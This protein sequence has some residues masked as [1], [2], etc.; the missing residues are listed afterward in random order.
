MSRR[1]FT[2]L[3]LVVVLAILAVLTG[4]L[5][6]AVQKVR[7][8]ASRAWCLN[9][10]RQVG[11]AWHSHHAAHG[12]F[13]TAG[14]KRYVPIVFLAPGSP[15][16]GGPRPDDQT[17]TWMYQ[18]LPYLDQEPLWRQEGVTDAKEACER[19]LATPVGVYFCPARPR[20]R[21][22]AARL[23]DLD[24]PPIGRIR[25]GNDYAANVGCTHS[26][27]GE[28]SWV[29][30]QP[31]G[32]FGGGAPSELR[33]VVRTDDIRDGLA[34]TILASERWIPPA[35]YVGPNLWNTLGYAQP[36]PHETMFN[37]CSF[38]LAQPPRPDA[39]EWAP[40]HQ[41]QVG[42]T[43]PGGVNVAFADGSVRPV[44][45]GVDPTT[46]VMLC[47]RNDGRAIPASY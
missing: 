41:P 46:W 22:W 20:P 3:E 42:S 31:N 23:T 8:A 43:H 29:P 18:L 47:V 45:Y 21:T 40:P 32:M 15:A 44:G 39:V 7:A 5:L 25:A 4:L 1:A 17:G 36:F 28:L 30:G 19:I 13:P 14:D 24:R 6:P 10:M 38:D 2:L 34:H 27:E 11:L 26:G 16:I 35:G 33:P 12:Y 9:N 37:A